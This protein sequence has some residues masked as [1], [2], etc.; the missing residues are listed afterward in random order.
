[1]SNKKSGLDG[2]NVLK[3]KKRAAESFALAFKS[4]EIGLACILLLLIVQSDT[5]LFLGSEQKRGG[6]CLV[7]VCVCDLFNHVIVR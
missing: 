5:S 2:E 3:R 6:S 1:M 4:T 7:S